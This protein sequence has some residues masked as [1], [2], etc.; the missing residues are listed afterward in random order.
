M[1]TQLEKIREV[2]KEAWNKSSSGWKKW[3]DL[4]MNFLQPMSSEM[5]QMLN[6]NDTDI[7]L[8]VATGT[9]EP[10]LT[11]A[12]LLKSGKVVGT[13]LAEEMLVVAEEKANNRRIKNFKTV[14]CDVSS[15]PFENDT[16]NA[17]S[18]RLGI[19]FFPDIQLALMEMIRVLK[20]GGRIV[21]SVWDMK[22]KNFWI[23]ASM[24]TMI[25]GLG[26]NP[27]SGAPG[28]FRCSNDGFMAE[29]MRH[30]GLRNIQERKIEGKMTCGT[31]ET[32][33][34]FI[35]EL[36]SPMAYGK[37]DED[38]KQKIKEEILVK[39]NQ[40]CENGNIEMESCSIIVCGEKGN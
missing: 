18:C 6:L 25:S 14:C 37:A 40:K 29:H 34:S 3:D 10:G 36:A 39:V 33:W 19:M 20:P 24:E 26:L 21:I 30:A 2:Q 15:L 28:L 11:I 9:G 7:V 32:Y 13:D 38:L 5:I 4:M 31:I 22:E 23:N 8:D 16:F 1:N 12:S 35:T 17:I 27:P